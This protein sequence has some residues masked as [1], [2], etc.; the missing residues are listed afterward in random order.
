LSAALQN[1]KEQGQVNLCPVVLQISSIFFL[2]LLFVA[3]T[4]V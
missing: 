2:H 4:S 3:A 1:L